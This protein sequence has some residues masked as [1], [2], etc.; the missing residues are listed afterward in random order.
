MKKILI[1]AIFIGFGALIGIPSVSSASMITFFQTLNYGASGSQVTQLQRFLFDQGYMKTLPTGIFQ[2]STEVALKAF[3]KAAD[4]PQTG[5]FN[6]DTMAAA[7]ARLQTVELAVAN[8]TN[9]NTPP[10]AKLA[11]QTVSHTSQLAAVLSSIIGLTPSKTITWQATNFPSGLGVEI[12]LIKKTST[13]PVAYSLVRQLTHN[14]PN[15]GTFTWTPQ[16]NENGSDLY[17]EIGCASNAHG[18]TT[19]NGCVSTTEPLSVE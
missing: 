12:N 4:V 16:S 18:A 8:G 2:H 17:L 5:T 6:A 19:P 10:P 1:T 9:K 7:N 3:Q 14:A 15:T 11:L 13:S